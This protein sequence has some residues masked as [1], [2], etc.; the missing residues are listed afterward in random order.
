MRRRQAPGPARLS[1]EASAE[2]GLPGRRLVLRHEVTAAAGRRPNASPA[3]RLA[4]GGD[5]EQPGGFQADARRGFTRRRQGPGQHRVPPAG[6]AMETSGG[7]SWG[8][9]TAP[10]QQRKGISFISFTAFHFSLDHVS[11]HN[12]VFSRGI[13]TLFGKYFS[14]AQLKSD[15]V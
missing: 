2:A 9:T 8:R 1:A 4:G 13:L 6:A 11:E 15:D 10:G 12:P 5:E 3:A 14:L 7:P